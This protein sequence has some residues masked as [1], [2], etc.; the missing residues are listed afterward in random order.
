MA[1]NKGERKIAKRAINK[2]KSNTKV[3][4]F[5]SKKKKIEK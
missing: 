5:L 1:I 3:V 4:A 2:N